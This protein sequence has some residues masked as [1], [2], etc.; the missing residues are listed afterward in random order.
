MTGDPRGDLAA[1]LAEAGD[2]SLTVFAEEPPGPP[3]LPAFVI[4]PGEP[5]RTASSAPYCRE[6]WRLRLTALVPIDAVNPLDD[7]DVLISL[8]RDV[9][10]GYPNTTYRGVR[11]APGRVEIGGKPMRGASVEVDVDI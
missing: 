7:L 1:A 11:L 2:A 9:I 4:Q 10:N 8:A 3:A 6:T 5:Y